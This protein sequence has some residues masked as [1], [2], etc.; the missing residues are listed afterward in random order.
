MRKAISRLSKFGRT[1]SVVCFFLISLL[2]VGFAESWPPVAPEDL[3]MTS[4][5][6]Q[7]GAPAVILYREE[8]DDDTKNEHS[9]Y[10][11]IKILTDA[12]LKYADIELPY[13]R[14]AF[15]IIGINGRTI[16]PDGSIVKFSGKPFD[17]VIEKSHGVKVR[18]KS[19]SLPDVTVGSIID[20]RYNLSY[21]DNHLFPPTWDV[22]LD[23]FQKKVSF[24]FFPYMDEWTEKDTGRSGQGVAWTP[25]LPPDH[26]PQI[27]N[28]I[29]TSLNTKGAN[30]DSVTLDMENVPP[31]IKE[32]YMLPENLL[33]WRVDF[34]YR[35]SSKPEDYWKNEGK[36]WNKE[37]DSFLNRKTGLDAALSQVIAPNDTPEVKVRKI[38]AYVSKMENWSF[39]PDKPEQEIQTLGIRVNRGAEDVL[40]QRSGTHDDLNRLFVAM[41]RSAGVLA[42]LIRVPDRGEYV[43]EPK[44]LSTEQ[45]DAELA[46]VQLDGKDVFLDPGTQF[47]PYGLLP[48]HYSGIDGL[49]QSA[50]KGTEF[51]SVPL[52]VYKQTMIQRKAVL[53]LA[54][55]GMEDG[56]VTVGF[57][58]LEGMARRQ[59][60]AQTDATGRKKLLEDE[61]K[62]WLPTGTEVT[63]SNEPKWDDGAVGLIAEFKIHG[64]LAVSAG[65][66]RIIPLHIF[67][68]NDS[69]MFPAAQRA[70]AIYFYDP[71]CVMDEVHITLPQGTAVENLPQ[72]DSIHLEYALYDSKQTVDKPAEIVAT[73]Q[74][75]MGGLA[76]PKDK[77][78]ELKMFYD[79][80]SADDGQ[81]VLLK[82]ASHAE[83]N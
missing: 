13:D 43:F 64:P 72:N 3:K 75:V 71:Y 31:L 21:G 70:N 51:G 23:L 81:Q 27:H 54:D 48:W 26:Q 19:F 58:G 69:P 7:S 67:E 9:Y 66:R 2:R 53:A 29:Q 4:I 52:P 76:F 74:I 8:T 79:K 14:R 32:P 56:T 22:Q 1:I 68:V 44:F 57:F 65:K 28:A 24:T 34:Y 46:I 33:R 77:Y 49:R 5:A 39:T 62:K 18:V 42:W 35:T 40:Q 47:C 73:R 41:V 38:Y 16:H 17:K 25:Y 11:R 59:Q 45:F 61:I 12:G 83:G 55:D 6:E 78:K 80:V 36:Y 82:G 37:V 15:T 60:A 20:I 50:A 63:I 10:K 30:G